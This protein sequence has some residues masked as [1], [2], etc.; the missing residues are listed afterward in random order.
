[1]FTNPSIGQLAHDHHREMIAEARQRQL[2][3]QA[4]RS[5][6]RI[7]RVPSSLSRGLTVLMAKVTAA[8]SAPAELPS[9]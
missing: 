6:S 7:L 4:S 3:H 8:F 2:S 5:G 1:M 9:E